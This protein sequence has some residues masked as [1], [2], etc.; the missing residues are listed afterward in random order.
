M[1]THNLT[2]R[3]Q[4]RIISNRESE[5]LDLISKE[6][7]INEIAKLLFL[8]PHTIVTHRKNMMRK[9][10]VKNAAGMIRKAFELGLLSVDQNTIPKAS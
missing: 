10:D 6:F 9:L 7:T 3:F 8:S 4:A 2:S 1:I 5:I